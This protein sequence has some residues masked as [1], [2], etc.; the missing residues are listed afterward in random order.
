MSVAWETGHGGRSSV[1]RHEW[2]GIGKLGDGMGKIEDHAERERLES[3]ERA[4]THTAGRVRIMP[5]SFDFE[6]EE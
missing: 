2:K 3:T 6:D 4:T 5:G 1:A